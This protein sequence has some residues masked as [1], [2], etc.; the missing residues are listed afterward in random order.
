MGSVEDYMAAAESEEEQ[1]QAE[2][3]C[4]GV[5][6]CTMNN[7]H[8]E[9]GVPEAEGVSGQPPE[10]AK[11]WANPTVGHGDVVNAAKAKEVEC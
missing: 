10:E 2:A 4:G 5:P 1:G 8:P 9:G 11:P 3:N 6:G 7:A